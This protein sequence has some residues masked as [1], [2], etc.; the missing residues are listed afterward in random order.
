MTAYSK[1]ALIYVKR[2]RT[3][4]FR[5]TITVVIDVGF[6]PNQKELPKTDTVS[7]L[8]YLECL[9]FAGRTHHPRAA[10]LLSCPA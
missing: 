4:I 2:P 9:S 3:E 8:D 10:S 5:C 6:V 7:L 1:L